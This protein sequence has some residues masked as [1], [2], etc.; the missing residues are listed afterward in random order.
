MN[1]QKVHM[2]WGDRFAIIDHFSPSDEQIRTAFKLTQAE[3]DTARTLRA[4]GTFVS[5]QRM[6]MSHYSSLFS[7]ATKSPSTPPTRGN[8]TMNTTTKV[9]TATTHTMPDASGK[10]ETASKPV[11]QPKK[12]GRKGD[13]I[14]KALQSVTKTH[15]PVDMFTQQHD[16]SLAVLRQAKRFIETLDPT[17]AKTIGKINVR[18]DKATKK[19]MIWREDV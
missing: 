17:Q 19:L 9:S 13:K 11:K 2:S 16:V 14:L 10:P 18:Q 12:R 6:N 15:T 3:L 4:A 7:D 1:K 8:L 5:T